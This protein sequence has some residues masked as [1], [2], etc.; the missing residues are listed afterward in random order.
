M[1]YKIHYILYLKQHRIWNVLII[2][3]A[4]FNAVRHATTFDITKVG[5][6]PIQVMASIRYF[7]TAY[8]FTMSHNSCFHN[9]KYR[10]VI[11]D[12]LNHVSCCIAYCWVED[13]D[14]QFRRKIITRLDRCFYWLG[15]LIIYYNSNMKIYYCMHSYRLDIVAYMDYIY[16]CLKYRSRHFNYLFDKHAK[17]C[18]RCPCSVSILILLYYHRPRDM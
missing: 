15:L 6:K 5:H 18:G 8:Q 16:E 11:L 13:K 1:S 3:P 14:L 12:I 9:H 4:I 2:G 7:F 10:N 17:M